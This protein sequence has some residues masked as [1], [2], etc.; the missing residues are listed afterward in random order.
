MFNLKMKSFHD[1]TH[2]VQVSGRITQ[3]SIAEN[4]NAFVDVLGT[5]A[6]SS[7]VILGLEDVEHVDS[8]GVGWL[9]TS[10]RQ[11][12]AEGGKL[13]LHSIPPSVKNV[14]GMLH[15]DK[16]LT[17]AASEGEARQ[18]VEKKGSENE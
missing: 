16:V 2:A 3:A 18:V 12:G 9:L 7:N 14:F 13:V 8:C 5:D 11:F 4:A 10:N 15:L 6:F 1:G 17:L